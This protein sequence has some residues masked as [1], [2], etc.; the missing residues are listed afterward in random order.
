[1]PKKTAINNGE[2]LLYRYSIT[3][4]D[5]QKED[6]LLSA[7]ML[8][9]LLVIREFEEKLLTE[10]S[11]TGKVHGPLHSSIGQEAVAI[12]VSAA[13]ARQDAIT[14]THR[15]HHHFLAKTLFYYLPQD[16]DPRK[17]DAPE[18]SYEICSKLMTEILGLEAGFCLGRGGSMHLAD[19]Q[20]GVLG[21]NA[22]A[23][24][25]ISIAAGAALKE[26][27]THGDAAALTYFGEGAINQGVF[28]ECANMAVLWK[29]PVIFLLENNLYAVTTY[30]GNSVSVKPIAKRGLG[31]G[32]ASYVVDGMDPTAIRCCVQEARGRAVSSKGPTL[33]ECL[34]YRYKHHGGSQDGTAFRYRTE[35]E[36]QQWKKKDPCENYPKQ[37]MDNKTITFDQLKRMKETAQAV[38][39]KACDFVRRQPTP[40][41][42]RITFGLHCD[43]SELEKLSYRELEDY[44]ETKQVRFVE[45][46]SATLRRWMEKDNKVFVIGEEVGRLGGAFAATKGLYKE[47]P[48]RTIDSPISEA[49]FSGIG[50]GAALRG[51]RAVIEIMYP[52]FTMPGA[53]TLMN[54][55]A[56]IRYTYGS[57]FDV[58]VVVR[59]RCAIGSGYGAQHSLD[60]AALYALY[61]GWRIVAPSCPFDV[62]GLLNTA[63]QSADPVLFIEHALLYN[64]RG[65][66]PKD[67]MDFAI[68]FGKAKVYGN[69]KD[70]TIVSYSYMVTLCLEAARRVEKEGIHCT[71]VD[72]RTLDYL[73]IDWDC[74]TKQLEQN[75]RM[76]ICEQAPLHGS[77]GAQIADK[78]Q[79]DCFTFLDAPIH[80]VGAAN[81][82][83]PVSKVMETA[84]TPQVEDIIE[85]IRW[86][87]R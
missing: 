52:D 82:P 43:G 21:T 36:V 79:R 54:Q 65:P 87:L 9:Y 47:F 37:L 58:P 53:D 63:M 7:Q 20:S 45:S 80:R 69:G 85:A 81:I 46:I 62:I 70:I 71:L 72:L 61:P 77:V 41:T 83:M 56:K 5:R 75:G 18:A 26:K 78:L 35:E 16:Y 59:T 49:G 50:L 51:C 2:T 76:L 32:L 66:I 25:G 10:F 38:I 44:T 86:V 64:S 8:Q 74:L 73:H 3:D 29:L 23:G 55:I 33:I 40:D 14:S 28:A 22:I 34:T 30:A 19:K 42:S 13:L 1:V 60:P 24:G 15:G 31:F 68:P 48:E 6:P 27:L 11:D 12:G 17:D 4:S 39:Q 84:A 57:Q 67:D